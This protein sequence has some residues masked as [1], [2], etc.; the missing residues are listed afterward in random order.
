MKKKLKEK[1]SNGTSTKKIKK[2]KFV[3]KLKV[4]LIAKSKA[5]KMNLEWRKKEKS[6]E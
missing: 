3:T 1:K 6:E 2:R 4:I 5:S